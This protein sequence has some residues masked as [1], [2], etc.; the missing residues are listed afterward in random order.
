VTQTVYIA[1]KARGAGTNVIVTPVGLGA[2]V[3]V[4]TPVNASNQPL[5]TGFGHLIDLTVD[6]KESSVS[7]IIDLG[8]GQY[9]YRAWWNPRAESPSATVSVAGTPKTFPLNPTKSRDGEFTDSRPCFATI[10]RANPRA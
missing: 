6:G 3:I 4:V 7:P 5:G 2:G 8:N 9:A 1:P 10:A